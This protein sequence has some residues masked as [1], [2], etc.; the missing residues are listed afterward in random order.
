M[1]LTKIV[2]QYLREFEV[3]LRELEKEWTVKNVWFL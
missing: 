3:G 2:P 1:V